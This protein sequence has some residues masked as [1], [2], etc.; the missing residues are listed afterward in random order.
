VVFRLGTPLISGAPSRFP[1]RS[2]LFVFLLPFLAVTLRISFEAL[3]DGTVDPGGD[4]VCSPSV[5][6]GDF[7]IET[8]A[9]RYASVLCNAVVRKRF[10]IV[11]F[12]VCLVIPFQFDFENH[13]NWTS[14]DWV[15]DERPGWNG[16]KAQVSVTTAVILKGTLRVCRD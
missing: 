13:L 9:K 8:V 7:F 15:G 3:F 10:T 12:V 11:F 6:F 14:V 2:A 16:A 1:S 5:H 4:S